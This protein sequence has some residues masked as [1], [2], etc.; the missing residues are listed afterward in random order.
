MKETPDEYIKKTEITKT[1]TILFDYN[2]A[3]M[4]MHTECSE[5]LPLTH[6]LRIW[7]LSDQKT[8]CAIVTIWRLVSS[9]GFWFS[10]DINVMGITSNEVFI[11]EKNCMCHTDPKSLYDTHILVDCNTQPIMVAV[12]WFRYTLYR[13]KIAW[14]NFIFN[15][16]VQ[17]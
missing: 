7:L 1:T 10:H 14:Y 12:P 15:N 13:Y 3:L 5:S 9:F 4:N 8:V 6:L 16:F 11:C 2:V 17:L